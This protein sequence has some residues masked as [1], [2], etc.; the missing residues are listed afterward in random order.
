[1]LIV[2][3]LPCL[4]LRKSHFSLES[5]S[6]RT[7]EI[8]V[9]VGFVPFD[10]E[11]A[12]IHYDFAFSCRPAG[13]GGRHSRGTCTIT[14][15]HCYSA[16]TFPNPGTYFTIVE[17][18]CEFYVSTFRKQRVELQCFSVSSYVDFIHVIDEN[19]EMRIAH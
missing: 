16:S 7:A 13:D 5:E 1:M 11:C 10:V 2:E 17:Y 12:S 15:G 4:L 9:V 3:V 19:D 18:L 14:T 8:Y 6:S